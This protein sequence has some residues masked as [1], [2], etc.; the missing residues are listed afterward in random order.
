MDLKILDTPE[1][2]LSLLQEKLTVSLNAISDAAAILRKMEDEGD[3]ISGIPLGTIRLLHKVSDG[4]MLADVAVRFSGRLRDRIANLPL[5]KQKFLC[6]KEG[7]I[8][9]ILGDQD[10][11]SLQP[12][13]LT[14]EQQKMVFGKGFIRPPAAQRAWL[15]S[16]STPLNK[17]TSV[18]IDYEAQAVF[19]KGEKITKNTLLEWLKEL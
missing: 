17:R 5:D 7:K 3:D 14:E 8:E 4:R 13:H 9:V 19:Y 12:D 15:Q 6:G 10:K 1:K 2:R 11:I 16:H 18:K